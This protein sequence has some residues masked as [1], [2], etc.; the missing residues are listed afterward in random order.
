LTAQEPDADNPAV[1]HLPQWLCSPWTRNRLTR[2][3]FHSGQ[4]AVYNV[5]RRGLPISFGGP[6]WRLGYSESAFPW[7]AGC[8]PST[9]A[10]PRPTSLLD[11]RCRCFPDVSNPAGFGHHAE[12]CSRVCR[13]APTWVNRAT[14][15]QESGDVSRSTRVGPRTARWRSSNAHG[16]VDRCGGGLCCCGPFARADLPRPVTAVTTYGEPLE[17]ELAPGGRWSARHVRVRLA[18]R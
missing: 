9:S 11:G 16:T 6:P 10:T 12:T 3:W 5:A 17:H 4:L 14:G 13:S 1:G 7:S 2:E 18:H 15:I 8:G